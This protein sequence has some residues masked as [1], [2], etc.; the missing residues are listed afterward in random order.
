MI[1]SKE[2][3]HFSQKWP[4]RN[5]GW[6]L[7]S[8]LLFT[9]GHWQLA[10]LHGAQHHHERLRL[11]W[12]PSESA[13]MRVQLAAGRVTGAGSSSHV[14]SLRHES[15]G[16]LRTASAAVQ[17]GAST[18]SSGWKTSSSG[19]G[20]SSSSRGGLLNAS[21]ASSRTSSSSSSPGSGH[22]GAQTAR[23]TDVLVPA[24]AA[25]AR[26]ATDPA[27]LARLKQAA[28]APINIAVMTSLFWQLPVHGTDGCSVDGVPL[29]CHIQNGGTEVSVLLGLS[30]AFSCCNCSLNTQVV[31]AGVSEQGRRA[32]LSCRC[33]PLSA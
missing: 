1:R 28:A 18:N 2:V 3:P 21:D 12:H 11:V 33:D 7:A 13:R 10:A 9:V 32:L 26:A 24:L 16:G 4:S 14:G 25:A 27:Y 17:G 8:L 5:W 19:S 20:N 23:H 15:H 30:A 29:N 6:L 31:A 22:P